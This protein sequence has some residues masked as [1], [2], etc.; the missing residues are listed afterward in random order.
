MNN[1]IT[2]GITG[3]R[4][5]VETEE[6]KQKIKQLF[7]K[8]YHQNREV[9]LISPL[10]DGADRLVAHIYLKIFKEKSHLIVPMP[11]DK[12]RYMEDFDSKSKIEFLNY[13]KVAKSVIEVENTQGCHYRS[14]G[15]YVSDKCNILLALGDGTF[16]KKSGGTGEIVSY[17]KETQK[18]IIYFLCKRKD[19]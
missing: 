2:V 19:L 12:E 14:L 9:K 7:V 6:L 18:E 10:A 8:M 16:N 13:L 3:H 11:F 5:I 15:I 17:A 4:D 1:I